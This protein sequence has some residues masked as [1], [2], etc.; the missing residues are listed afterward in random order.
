VIRLP[1]AQCPL[2][3]R[4]AAHG[5]QSSCKNKTSARTWVEVGGGVGD[6]AHCVVGRVGEVDVEGAKPDGARHMAAD[7]D[8]EHDG[9]PGRVRVLPEPH[10]ARHC[11]RHYAR[12]SWSLAGL[13]Y[14]M[15]Q[16]IGSTTGRL[17]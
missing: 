12:R 7:H 13:G 11:R 3:Y 8:V 1:P 14:D 17:W 5:G 4:P 10:Q 6:D 2:P 9:L 15:A 16:D